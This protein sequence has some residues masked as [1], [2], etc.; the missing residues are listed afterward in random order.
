MDNISSAAELKLAIREKQMQQQIKGQLLKEELFITFESL[1]PASLLKSTLAEVTSS[2]YLI[3]NMLGAI[4]GIISGYIT[5]KMSVG[6]SHN[7][8][9]NILG[10][11]LQFNVSN[12]VAQHPEVIKT[13]GTFIIDKLFRR[14]EH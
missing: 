9:R 10:T 3:D 11:V 8:F 2:P 7:L 4:T 14:N 13:L 5:K 1:K 12:I 6:T